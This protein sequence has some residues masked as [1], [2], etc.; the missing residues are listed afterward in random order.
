MVLGG[1][2]TR[3]RAWTPEPRP[4]GPV[5]IFQGPFLSCNKLGNSK[6]SVFLGPVGCS[7]KLSNLKRKSGKP[8]MDT[9]S[10]LSHVTETSLWSLCKHQVVSSKCNSTLKQPSWCPESYRIGWRMYVQGGG[11]AR[12]PSGWCQ[13]CSASKDSWRLKGWL[14]NL[15]TLGVCESSTG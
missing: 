3:K 2:C 4:L 7:S 9:A 10:W 8:L 6:S 11:G 13:K 1:L 14:I 15:L 12:S 5:R